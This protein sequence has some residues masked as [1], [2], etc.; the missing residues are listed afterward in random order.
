MSNSIE[1]VYQRTIYNGDLLLLNNA[2]IELIGT[3]A[4]GAVYIALNITEGLTIYSLPSWLE[5]K[6]L[7]SLS[8]SVLREY[9]DYQRVVLGHAQKV[10]LKN[11]G[12][13]SIPQ[14]LL[15]FSHLD[16][17]K[18]NVK[19]KIFDGKVEIKPVTD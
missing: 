8:P 3:E 1:Q 7:L 10:T 16:N 14:P 18:A 9:R 12:L 19:I 5:I 6:S 13:I 4:Y 17:L 11:N 15:S 2:I